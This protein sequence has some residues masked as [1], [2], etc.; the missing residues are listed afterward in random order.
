MNEQS[1]GSTHEVALDSD[2]S[3]ELG[4]Q[5]HL[6]NLVLLGAGAT[7]AIV[8]H[9]FPTALEKGWRQAQAYDVAYL[10]ACLE[11]GVQTLGEGMLNYVVTIDQH[12][13]GARGAALGYYFHVLIIHV[14]SVLIT[15]MWSHC[16]KKYLN[17]DKNKK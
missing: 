17:I 12:P 14:G 16:P 10:T 6:Y 9:M 11:K 8:V 15:S 13:L 4:H 5:R 3:L 2:R 7:G 1:T